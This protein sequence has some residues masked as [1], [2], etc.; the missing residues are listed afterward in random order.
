MPLPAGTRL[1]PY[2]I[3]GLIGAGGMGQVYR[4][5]D[6]S[7][8]RAVAIKVL[9][10]AWV[11]DPERV[12]RLQREAQV[13]A[14]LNHPNIAH[15]HG[16]EQRDGSTALVMELV[17]GPTLDDRI[18]QGAI[19]LEEALAI[20]RQIADALDAAHERGIVHRDLKPAN[21]KLRDDGTVKV[22]DF[23][24]AKA[25]GPAFAPGASAG[26]P[27]DLT[28]SPTIT[29]PAMTAH[30]VI[31]GT[32]AYMAPEQAKGRLVDKR[33]DI[34]AFG[35]V[36]YEMLTG[37]RLFEGEDL[38][39]TL[40]SVVKDQP[41]LS[42]AP[43]EVH[44]LLGR[45]LEKDPRRR[46]RDIGDAW[47]L[48]GTDQVPAIS[49][50]VRRRSAW[51]WSIA[52]VAVI[53]VA[54]SLGWVALKPSAPPS[55]LYEFPVDVP[56]PLGG[57]PGPSF[58]LSPDGRDL[59]ISARGATNATGPDGLRLWLRPLAG[60]PVR[61]LTGTEGAR[62]PFWSPDGRYIGF[63][64]QGKLKKIA[65]GGPAQTLC[66]A[67]DGRGGTW[68]ADGVILFAPSPFGQIHRVPDGGG[69]P[70]AVTASADDMAPV[71][72]FPW[73]LPD[74]RHFLYSDAAAGGDRNG[75]Y[76]GSIDGRP[77]RR[78]LPDD[79]NAIYA[80]ATSGPG[81]IL[82]VRDG[83]LMAQ[84]FD[85]TRLEPAGDVFVVADG[86]STS[87]NRGHYGVSTAAGG[88][89][90]Y[91]RDAAAGRSNLTQL[92]WRD[93]AGTALESLGRPARIAEVA[94]SP[95]GTRAAVNIVENDTA[96]DIWVF[97]LR[98]GEM[99]PLTTEPGRDQHPQWSP[100]GSRIAFEAERLGA[101][102]LFV[103]EAGGGR[104]DVALWPTASARGRGGPI[105]R[106]W[107]LRDWS[108]DG[109]V[110]LMETSAVGTLIDLWALRLEGDAVQPMPYLQTPFNESRGR[111]SPDG[112]W[113]AYQSN[114]SGRP[115]IYIRP[116]PAADRKWLVST[117]GGTVPVWSRDGRELYYIAPTS[118][119]MA[120]AIAA[121]DEINPGT[122]RAL[123][124]NAGS[125]FDVS[126]DGRFLMASPV[127]TVEGSTAQASSPT[128]VFISDW[129]AK[130][131]R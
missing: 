95:D 55:P 71:R 45:C 43:R 20:A 128:L 36:L 14:S 16:L 130:L 82:F 7:L 79:S 91:R 123:F 48:V 106:D 59:A 84:P 115:E 68:N 8:K 116:F 109:R 6:T 78:L 46:L 105:L 53:T 124:K 44:R 1:G 15:V 102:T 89:L 76:V 41:D 69:Q 11:H 39:E 131:G 86:L 24:L 104:Q 26:Q 62:Y 10:P 77:A 49:T 33:A 96:S 88:S 97:D 3:V 118:E 63:F 125:V 51:P 113:V 35:V 90:L 23:G 17:E 60:G 2:E 32:A 100:D 80:P 81:S 38:T 19:P 25:M 73:F 56:M 74:G 37:R 18:R 110:L 22:L 12:A 57:S 27:G 98:R 114:E 13:L 54:G 42:A 121:G 101:P 30:G 111:F 40:A 31:L 108:R 119:L 129:R 9:P 99:S 67:E 72:R 64:A 61:E 50:A 117:A 87:G 107:S 52:T 93:R 47:D 29:S 4:A 66:D 75:I 83:T 112:R 120:V 21:V 65:P 70:V 28:D 122:A 34:W 127:E 85:T 92:A 103:R 126:R 58:A 94:L 5:T